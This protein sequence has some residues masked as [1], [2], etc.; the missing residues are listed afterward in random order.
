MSP[1]IIPSGF[2]RSYLDG[3]M[4][5]HTLLA[6]IDVGFARIASKHD[7]V[8]VEG[9]GHLGVGSIIGMNNAAVAKRLGLDVVIVVPAGL[10]ST[11]DT[12]TL[13][14]CLC[15]EHGVRVRGV[16]INRVLPDK[17]EMISEYLPKALG[18]WKVP[19]LGYVPYDDILG[20]PTMR[21]FEGLFE[22]EL[23]SGHQHV[24]RRF[25][26]N[27][28]GARSTEM[29][30]EK[31]KP[32][33]LTITPVGREDIILEVLRHNEKHGEE[34][35]GGLILTERRKPSPEIL[36]A[37]RKSDIPVLCVPIASYKVLEMITSFTAKTRNDDPH[38]IA[39]A[40]RL[41]E[42][43]IDFDLLA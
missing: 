32:R 9:T 23:I 19:I 26:V 37:I 10:G 11:F 20:R 12:L 24:F 42:N 6:R 25:D 13:N 39:Q 15:R 1:V 3:E 16:I 33:Q 43:E 36:D 34:G 35:G 30:R 14:V 17:R 2:T 21:D 8:V 5:C 29:F 22:T 40:I 28:V 18:P 27:R 38:K 7:F 31:L 41:F 4:S